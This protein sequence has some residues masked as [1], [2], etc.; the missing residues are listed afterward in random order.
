MK[1]IKIP[2][3]RQENGY[4]CGPATLK[5]ALEFFGKKISQKKLAKIA[6]T[7]KKRGTLRKDMVKTARRF[8]FKAKAFYWGD[9][10]AIKSFLAEKKMVIVIFVEPSEGENHYAV[11]AGVDPKMIVLND[12]LNGRNFR[13]SRKEFVARWNKWKRWF[14]VLDKEDQ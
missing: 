4:F 2:Y 8:G 12:S 6:G 5:M 9:F 10:K 13:M 11:V 3:Y 7:N 1:K 14:M